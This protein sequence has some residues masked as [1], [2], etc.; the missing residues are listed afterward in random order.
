M[1]DA[2]VRGAGR[3]DNNSKARKLKN[4]GGNRQQ[5]RGEFGKN[6]REKI[7]VSEFPVGEG[8]M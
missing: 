2:S 6:T 1:C 5:E 7:T 3:V 8:G 4:R